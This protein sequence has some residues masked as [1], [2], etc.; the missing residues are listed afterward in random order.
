MI[1]CRDHFTQR[2]GVKLAL[3]RFATI[4]HDLLV[5]SRANMKWQPVQFTRYLTQEAKRN[6]QQEREREKEAVQK[7]NKKL[8]LITGF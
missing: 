4:C 6:H 1:R 5:E 3:K 8:D 7:K 2:D